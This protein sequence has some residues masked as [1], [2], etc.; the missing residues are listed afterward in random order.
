[1]LSSC[2]T[3]QGRVNAWLGF[4]KPCW[5]PDVVPD[6]SLPTSLPQTLS[7]V[8]DPTPYLGVSSVFSRA[9][10]SPRPPLVNPELGAELDGISVQGCSP[11]AELPQMINTGW[12]DVSKGFTHPS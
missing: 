9:E 8:T 6:S 4:S 11:H 7:L 2:S 3:S 5:C 10:T 1:M 12:T